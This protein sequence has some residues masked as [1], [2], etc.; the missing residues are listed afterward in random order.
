MSDPRPVNANAESGSFLRNLLNKR[1]QL[2]TVQ[3]S[4][5]TN[6]TLR[7]VYEDSLV[8]DLDGGH[9]VL[10]FLHAIISVTAAAE[11][12]APTA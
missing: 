4:L 12:Y 3:S 8:L 6:G 11:G 10:I 1:V 9:E 5:A 2:T 7:Q